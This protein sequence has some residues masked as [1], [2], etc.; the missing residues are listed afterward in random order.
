MLLGRQRVFPWYTEGATSMPRKKQS[1][2]QQATLTMMTH[3]LLL[4]PKATTT[5]E[6]LASLFKGVH[7]LQQHI[8]CLLAVATS[9]NQST[10][11]RGYT[12]G[13]VLHFVD[14]PH[15]R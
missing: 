11:H 3:I 15:L 9:E 12:H 8:P 13:I 7:A 2:S 10:R 5:D 4:Q 1:A 6:A 14:E